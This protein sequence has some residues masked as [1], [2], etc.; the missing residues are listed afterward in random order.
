MEFPKDNKTGKVSTTSTNIKIWKAFLNPLLEKDCSYSKEAQDLLSEL[1]ALPSNEW[2][3]GYIPIVNR[4]VELQARTS[5]VDCLQMCQAGLK[6]LHDTML[7]R[8]QPISQAMMCETREGTPS[9]SSRVI[10][11]NGEAKMQNPLVELPMVD[12]TN[13]N[14]ILSGDDLEQQLK[15]WADYGCM[16]SDAADHASAMAKSLVTSN[17]LEDKIFVLLGATSELGPA[18]PLADWGATIVA[19]SRPGS[20]LEALIDHV[21]NLKSNCTMVVPHLVKE[22]GSN[23]DQQSG[24]DVME[25]VPEVAQWIA[26]LYPQKRLVL[27]PL[28]YLDGEANV[29]AVTAMDAIVSF[30][31]QKRPDDV[32]LAYWISPGTPHVISKDAAL[33]AKSRFESSIPLWH[34]PFRILP[35]FG[36]QRNPISYQ[37]TTDLYVYNGLADLQGPNYALSKC[38]QQWR[39][40]LYSPKFIDTL[41]SPKAWAVSANVSPP[42]RT[43]SMIS[44]STVSTWLNGISAF[45]PMTVFQPDTARVLMTLLLLHDLSS[46]QSPT[47]RHPMTLFVDNSVHGGCW[48]MPYDLNSVGTISFVLGKLKG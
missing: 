48:R 16:E 1:E 14:K 43:Q 18:L 33:D 27:V 7:F 32:A 39:A 30:V 46:N 10:R 24:V 23:D 34:R 19:I 29:R 36:F 26:S 40:M 28:I 15:I 25:Y 45:P 21:K 17:V 2:R 31:M 12:E 44:H 6:E 5:P 11:G 9:I 4:M 37:A 22:V 41:D 20:K 35:S 47:D 8:S 42:A 3:H 13:S 38:I